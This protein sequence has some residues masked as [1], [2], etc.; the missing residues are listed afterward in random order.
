MNRAEIYLRLARFLLL[1]LSMHTGLVLYDWQEA[2]EQPGVTMITVP[3]A[4]L[5][6]EEAPLVT[7]VAD[8]SPVIK[9]Q[10]N[11]Q[12][13]VRPVPP[14]PPAPVANSKTAKPVA[15]QRKVTSSPRPLARDVPPPKK[16]IHIARQAFDSISPALPISSPAPQSVL[17]APQEVATAA[18]AAKAVNGPVSPPV[19]AAAMPAANS[20][21]RTGPDGSAVPEMIEAA[22]DFDS[23][24]LPEYPFLARQ[25][26]WQGVVWLLV[27][28]STEGLVEELRIERSCGHGVLDRAASRT[29]R[30]WRFIPARRAGQP[31]A[32]QVRIPVRFQLEDS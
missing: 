1:S 21:S 23:N 32:S 28:V 5:P 12:E 9:Q 11:A 26:H 14:D 3:V 6:V 25:K 15:R 10:Q 22:P 16:Q 20:E 27:N 2:S 30:Q 24:P 17:A 18:T 31:M 13:H 19:E 8:P 7:A 4:F 29:V